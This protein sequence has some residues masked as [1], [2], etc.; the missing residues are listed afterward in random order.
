MSDFDIVEH[1]KPRHCFSHPR[2]SQSSPSDRF[3]VNFHTFLNAVTIHTMV[4]TDER[5]TLSRLSSLSRT[6]FRP[7]QRTKSTSSSCSPR[8]QQALPHFPH[9][10]RSLLQGPTHPHWIHLTDSTFS[11]LYFSRLRLQTFSFF[12]TTT[13]N[14]KVKR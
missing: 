14:S 11:I 5:T 9:R 6:R 13:R 10:L 1:F 12:N 3:Q 7:R 2:I 4:N 8:L